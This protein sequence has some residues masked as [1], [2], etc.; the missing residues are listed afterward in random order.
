[1]TGT[2][3]VD[4]NEVRALASLMTWKT[5]L[6]NLPFGGAKGG[7]NVAPADLSERELEA[8]TRRFTA[9]ISHVLG[10]Y[11]DVPAPDMNTNPQV[12][13]WLMDAYSAKAGYTPAIVTGKPIEFGGAPG[14]REATGRGVIFTLEQAMSHAGRSL[15]GTTIAI[16][17]FGNVGTYAALTALDRGAKIVGISDISGD[18][19]NGD[20]L[21][22]AAAIELVTTGGSVVDLPGVD[23]LEPGA[24][25]TVDCDILIPAALGE[26]ITMENVGDVKAEWIVE[27]ANNPT[28]PDAD[29]AL[30]KSDVKVVPDILA[31]GGGVTGSYFEWTQNIQQ[32]TWDEDVFNERLEKRMKSTVDDT[33]A[34]AEKYG[35][36]MRQAAFAI[37]I[38]RV[39]QASHMRGYV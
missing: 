1:M 10:P 18:V 21:D 19:Y 29:E 13:A 7:V 36:S 27:G 25:L 17:G 20:G 4:I 26:V 39:A 9:S 28:T 22:I 11:R 30:Y 5:A 32:F 23:V 24:V 35:V 33:I 8:L 15:E 34:A 38:D 14:R 6:H 16:Q 31:N 2:T 12:M 37:S 3:A